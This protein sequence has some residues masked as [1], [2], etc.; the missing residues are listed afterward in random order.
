MYHPQHSGQVSPGKNDNFHPI[1]LLH[2]LHKLRA[3]LDFALFGKLVRLM[4]PLMQFL[5]VRPGL[6]RRLLSD[7]QSPTTP[8]PLA[9]D[10]YCQVHSG[11]TPPSY[12]PCRAHQK[13][14]SQRGLRFLSNAQIFVLFYFSKTFLA[15][16]PKGYREILTTPGFMYHPRVCLIMPEDRISIRLPGTS[17]GTPSTLKTRL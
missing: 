9:N 3:V 1:C 14:R 5:F 7:S 16:Q 11:L 13:K 17:A 10:S 4:Q 2:L 15:R 12:R 6:C 8:L